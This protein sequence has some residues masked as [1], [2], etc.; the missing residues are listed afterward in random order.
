MD[1]AARQIGNV[2]NHQ[3]GPV[4]VAAAAVDELG[5]V[6]PLQQADSPAA[7]VPVDISG[8]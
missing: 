6:V 1:P 4:G 5:G 3:R 8:L 2:Q 7:V